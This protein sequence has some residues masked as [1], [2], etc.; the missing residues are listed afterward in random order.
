MVHVLVA[1]EFITRRCCAISTKQAK[2][3]VKSYLMLA[4]L[5]FLPLNGRL[6]LYSFNYL[7]MLA[8]GTIGHSIFA[9]PINAKS[10]IISLGFY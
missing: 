5:K 9:L 3:T 4:T 8:S 1:V 2:I 10:E 7:I 6:L